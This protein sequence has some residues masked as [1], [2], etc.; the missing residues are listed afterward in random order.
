[1]YERIALSDIDN[2]STISKSATPPKY[3]SEAGMNGQTIA[4][5]KKNERLHS[6]LKIKGLRIKRIAI[7][8]SSTP[9]NGVKVW[10]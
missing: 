6:D 9:T 1:M 4:Q 3:L 8:R 10:A 5:K 7:D 2:T